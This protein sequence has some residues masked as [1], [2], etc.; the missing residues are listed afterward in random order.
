VLENTLGITKEN[1]VKRKSMSLD[2]QN[3]EKCD[4]G[5]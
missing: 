5:P 1:H 4:L 2:M 3:L